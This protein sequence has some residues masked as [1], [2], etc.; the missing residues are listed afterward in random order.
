MSAPGARPDSEDVAVSVV[1]PTIG[2]LSHLRACLESIDACNPG[3]HEVIVVDQS[4]AGDVARVVEDV[5]DAKRPSLAR[6]V[7]SSTRGVG[8]AQNLGLRMAAN[9]TVL[10]THDDC[11]V[12]RDWVLEGSRAA[13]RHDGA[14]VTGR[15]LPDGDPRSVPSTIVEPEP[16]DHSYR[17]TFNVLY[18]NNM[19]LPR[20]RAL[21]LGGFD[22]R[23]LHA[24]DNDFCYRWLKAGNRLLY[25]PALVV[26]HS[27]WRN[28]DEL[29][30]TYVRYG[31]GQGLF[32][33][34]QLRG[35]D[36]LVL[37][38]LFAD[39]RDGL[40]GVAALA[41]AGD[42]RPNQARGIL[43]GLP[44]GLARGWRIFAPTGRSRSSAHSGLS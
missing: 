1:V 25:E 38:F 28:D 2:R 4:G 32:Y 22:D 14:V 15:V 26:R 13:R 7:P 24:E 17:L 43:K 41:I 19:V 23:V 18:P 34:K 3:P 6:V 33:A 5:F 39:V 21:G 31:I 11:T 9:E 30:R 44:I 12:A 29:R 8:E 10:V 36:R 37:R 16:R 40:R 42:R 20:S 35:G 27:A